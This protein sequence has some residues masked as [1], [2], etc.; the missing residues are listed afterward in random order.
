MATCSLVLNMLKDSGWDRSTLF[1][2][3]A[4]HQFQKLPGLVLPSKLVI[5]WMAL[6][7][8]L[9]FLRR[10]GNA[11]TRYKVTDGGAFLHGAT[12]PAPATNTRDMWLPG[13]YVHIVNVST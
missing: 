10:P 9:G 13:K 5:V 12:Q 11:A 4:F 2:S 3:N 8:P 6:I 1:F 7:T